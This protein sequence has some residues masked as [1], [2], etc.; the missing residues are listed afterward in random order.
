MKGVQDVEPVMMMRVSTRDFANERTPTP[1]NILPHSICSSHVLCHVPPPSHPTTMAPKPRAN[2][3]TASKAPSKPPPASVTAAASKPPPKSRSRAPKHTPTPA[4]DAVQTRSQNA[5]ASA[6]N[7]AKRKRRTAAEKAADDQAKADAARAKDDAYDDTIRKLATMEREIHLNDLD[8]ST[9]RP[10]ITKKLERTTTYLNIPL[11][12]EVGDDVMMQDG[13]MEPSSEFQVDD[14]E[15]EESADAEATPQAPAKKKAKTTGKKS[16]V[17]VEDEPEENPPATKKPRGKMDVRSLINT[18]RVNVDGRV[19][20]DTDDHAAVTSHQIQKDS[21]P[22]GANSATFVAFTPF[23]LPLMLT[24]DASTLFYFS[25][26]SSDAQE[27]KKHTGAIHKWAEGIKGPQ[28]KAGSSRTSSTLSRIPST[29]NS[30]DGKA[31]ERTLVAS[32]LSNN[33]AIRSVAKQ[34]QLSTVKA[35]DDSEDGPLNGGLSDAD[36]T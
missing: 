19:E 36:K 17:E 34:K 10:R 21:A 16:T 5:E 6:G 4:E 13:T 29:A 15:S 8:M 20:C 23:C 18:E 9:P 14:E 27:P 32:S 24:L 2:A 33:V 30:A 11:G 3:K 25:H 7:G 35:E 22:K 26:C 31:S 12:S 1:L 28:S